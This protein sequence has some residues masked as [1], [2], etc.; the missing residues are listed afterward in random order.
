MVSFSVAVSALRAAFD[1][2]AN[3]AN[4][5]AN[6][7]SPGFKARRVHQQD[8]LDGGVRT[9]AVQRDLTQ[10]PLETTGRALDVAVSG[11]GYMAVDTPKGQR[12]T[13]FGSFALDA[14]G[15]IVDSQGNYLSPGFTVPLDAVAVNISRNGTVSATMPDGTIRDLGVVEVYTFPNPEGLLALGGG[16]FSPSASSGL[17]TAG[18]SGSAGFG[19]LIAGFLEGSNVSIAKELTDQIVTRASL[20]ANIAT[21]RTQDDMLGEILDTVG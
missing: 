7:S 8:T 4:N 5:L 16:L 20:S 10:G 14:E 12:F 9:A 17:P 21:I 2:Q 1:R 6:V 18:Q 11:P 3:T 13:R 19:E 15:R